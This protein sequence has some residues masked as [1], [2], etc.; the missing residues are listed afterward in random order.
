MVVTRFC[1]SPLFVITRD[2][3]PRVLEHLE[4]REQLLDH[5]IH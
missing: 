2:I 5:F 4:E 3:L 1:V